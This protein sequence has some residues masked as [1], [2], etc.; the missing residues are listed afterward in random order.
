MKAKILIVAVIVALVG[1]CAARVGLEKT[2]TMDGL[3]GAFRV[4][5]DRTQDKMGIN[6]VST[7]VLKDNDKAGKTDLVYG[8]TAGQPGIGKALVEEILPAISNA[9][10]GTTA[11]VFVGRGN[12]NISAGNVGNQSQGQGQFSQQQQGQGIH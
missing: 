4:Y 2:G 9:T 12:T 11:G 8:N 7:F 10:L 5:T 3:D 6:T 1:G